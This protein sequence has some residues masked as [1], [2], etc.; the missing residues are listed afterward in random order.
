MN[1][2]SPESN[3][4]TDILFYRVELDPTPSFDSPIVEDFSCPANNRRTEWEIK[5]V[6][7]GN[8]VIKG[9]SF[10]LEL[11]VDGFTSLSQ[12]IPYNAV[13]LASNE[14]GVFEELVPNFSTSGNSKA[15]RTIPPTNIGGVI[16]PGD[17]LRFSG[18]STKYM[19]Y[20]VQS[21]TG[22]EAVLSD[23]FIGEGGV[24]VSTTR[25]YGGRGSPLSSQI[26]CQYD[27]DL[28]PMAS[29]SK[30][31]SLQSK[32]EDLHLAIQN[33]VFVDRDGPTTQNGFI[34][35]VTFLDD[36][37]PQG[38]DYTLR[39]HSN[40]LT[41]VGTQGLA[42]VSVS[43]LN[44]GRTFTSCSG[45]LVMPSLGGLVKGLD[46]HGRV[47]ARNSEGYSLPVKAPESVAP[48][49]IP[50]APT[51]VSLDVVSATKLRVVFGSP[52]DNGGDTITQ[53]LIEWSTTSDFESVQSSTLDYL[54]GGSPF[55]KNIEGLATGSYYYVRVRAKNSQGYGIS[56]M[57]TPASLNPHQKPSPPTNVKLGIT[58]DT[59]LT[60]GWSQPL[61]S[62]GD[63]ISKYRI[64]WDT[65]PSF[66]SSSYLP[67]KGYVDVAS[68]VT[69]HTIQL[70]SSKNTYYVRVFAMNTSGSSSQ[71]LSTPSWAIPSVQ[72]PGRPHSLQAL[73]GMSQGT[74]DVSWQRPRVPAHSISCFNDGP[75]VK[76]C[77]TPYGGSLPASDGGEE[78]SE[79]ELEFNER[80]DFLG[81]DGGRRTYTGTHA[82]LSHLY[83]GRMYFIRVLARNSIGS[84]K[85]GEVV[86]VRGT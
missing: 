14:T 28:C 18:Q 32:L 84:G 23:A 63:S 67:N 65:K 72:V 13:A 24:Q 33:G 34:W 2:E 55:F 41:T 42:S 85:Y 54:A 79:Y 12:E 21:V 82:V 16:F 30:S 5:T 3:G 58:S 26:N 43:L 19:H 20:E 62:G 53:Y 35:R 69:S 75:T 8:S 50:G 38:S 25:H 10:R 86:S 37:Y 68:H 4:G 27:E 45:P 56:Q 46:Y 57:S 59:M 60:I 39:V 64:E 73:P 70:L 31:G 51:G 80:S 71:Q 40:S 1:F 83:S 78:I 52:S 6:A 11:E 61:S 66:A 44:S 47:S 22:T 29:E 48:M 77:P 7:Y 49:V 76:D 17:R 36:A 81:S 15:I 9:G 74:I